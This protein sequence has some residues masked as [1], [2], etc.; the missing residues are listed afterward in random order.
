MLSGKMTPLHAMQSLVGQ[1][2]SC[3]QCFQAHRLRMGA[4]LDSLRCAQAHGLTEIPPCQKSIL[5]LDF[6]IECS[7]LWN[8][9]GIRISDPD[10]VL[11]CDAGPEG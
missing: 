3:E 4:L 8:G 9:R 7:Q 6:W 1:L 5:D 11:T 2:Q 10:H